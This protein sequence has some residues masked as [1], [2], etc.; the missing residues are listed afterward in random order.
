M[1]YVATDNDPA[2][3]EFSCSTSFPFFFYPN[4]FDLRRSICRN[5]SVV[6]NKFSLFQLH[7]TAVKTELAH[8]RAG[9]GQLIGGVELMPRPVYGKRYALE[10]HCPAN[11]G[12]TFLNLLYVLAKRGFDSTSCAAFV[13]GGLW[14]VPESGRRLEV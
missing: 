4:L 7:A 11:T 9:V 3:S 14:V 5:S 6:E 1:R 10:N 12:I 13:L 8:D 2:P